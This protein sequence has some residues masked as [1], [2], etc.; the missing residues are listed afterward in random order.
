MVVLKIQVNVI[1]IATTRF[2]GSACPVILPCVA[3]PSTME[4]R[5]VKWTWFRPRPRVPCR[6]NPSLREARVISVHLPIRPG[7]LRRL[8]KGILLLLGRLL[9]LG[10]LLLL[11]VLLVRC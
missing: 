1:L 8:R 11:L 3:V 9:L 5:E 2:R 6:W 4:L 10:L 7:L